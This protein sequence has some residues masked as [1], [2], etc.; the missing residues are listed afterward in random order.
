[1]KRERR[2]QAEITSVP[3]KDRLELTGQGR[4]EAVCLYESSTLHLNK[5]SHFFLSALSSSDQWKIKFPVL[6]REL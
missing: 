2:E 1:M 5:V 3:G 4:T 6:P